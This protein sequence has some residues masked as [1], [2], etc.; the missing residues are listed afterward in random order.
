MQPPHGQSAGAPGTIGNEAVTVSVRRDL[1]GIRDRWDELVDSSA[2][3]SPFMKSWWVENAAGGEP[4]LVVVRNG[5]GSLLGGAAFERD[6]VGGPLLGVERLRSIGQGPLA[7][8]H[9]HVLAAPGMATVV[10]SEVARWLRDGDRVID[11]DGLAGGCELPWLLGATELATDVAPCLLL[12]P[13]D[14]LA[15]LPGRLRSTIKRSGRRLEKAG[16]RTRR[17]GQHDAPRAVRALLGLHQHR[18]V[19]ASALVDATERLERTLLAGMER[20]EVVIHELA[21][22]DTVVAS[23][24]ELV[25]GRRICFYQAGRLTD[26]ELRGSGSVL[27]AEVVRWAAEN[28]FEEFDLLRGDEPYKEE[29]ATRTRPLV[30]VRTGFGPRGRAAAAA[31]T[32]WT[33]LAPRVAR[34]REASSRR[35]GEAT[36]S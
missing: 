15:H 9:L 29:W 14:P 28:R 21:R 4:V 12:D 8:D 2:L 7:P 20:D 25:A 30:R 27:K 32:A 23:E 22:N 6:R 35:D 1:E 34:L 16:W 31:M 33:R 11:L 18:W 10:L 13:E 3:P 17:V 19:D 24:V 26:H 5:G 36:A